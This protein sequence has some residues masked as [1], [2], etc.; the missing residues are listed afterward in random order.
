MK[1]PTRAA[2]LLLGAV[3]LQLAAC[4]PA[5]TRPAAERC[6]P[7]VAG[8]LVDV[9]SLDQS[10]RAEIRYATRNN[11]TGAPLPGYERPRALLR[12]DAAAALAR[13]QRRLRAEGLGLKVFDAYR[14]VRATL[15]MVE[16]AERTGN[17][18]VLDQG[19]VA[20]RSGHNRGGTVDLTLVRLRSGAELEMGTPYDT[21]SEAAHTANATG[22]VLENRA[23]LLRAMEAEGF[24]NYEKE[25][26]HFRF[27]GDYPELDVP[28]RCF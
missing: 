2:A 19:Y 18:W 28:L 8:E 6:P 1:I 27:G 17:R 16:W 26:W 15:A 7:S 21:F 9:R 4:V 22:A 5:A 10:I 14:P 23:R 12:P 25:W 24:R 11:F 3:A 20:R 13:V